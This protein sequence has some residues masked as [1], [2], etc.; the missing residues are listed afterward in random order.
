MIYQQLYVLQLSN[1]DEAAVQPLGM[2]TNIPLT[3][4]AFRDYPTTTTE[5]RAHSIGMVASQ[6]K[7]QDWAVK[8]LS[9]FMLSWLDAV[10]CHNLE[11]LFCKP[12][13]CSYSEGR[14]Y[15]PHPSNHKYMQWKSTA[16]RDPFTCTSSFTYQVVPFYIFHVAQLLFHGPSHL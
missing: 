10:N 4:G 6:L 15:L 12:K 13:Y 2:G 11:N 9:Q 1:T 3:W 5:C 14:D 16:R 8:N 7:N